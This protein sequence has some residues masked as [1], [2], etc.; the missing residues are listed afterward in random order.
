[1]FIVARSSTQ[2]ASRTRGHADA[3][4]FSRSD[5]ARFADATR[6]RPTSGRAAHRNTRPARARHRVIARP[7]ERVRAEPQSRQA[8]PSGGRRLVDEMVGPGIRR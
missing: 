3:A 5:S 8:S 2:T 4:S 6:Y 7:A 1:M